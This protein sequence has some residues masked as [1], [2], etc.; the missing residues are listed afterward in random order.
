MMRSETAH[1]ERVWMAFPPERSS[2]GHPEEE[3]HEAR[4]AWAAIIR[5]VCDGLQV[6]SPYPHNRSWA[7]ISADSIWLLI[8]SRSSTK[9]SPA[10]N[11]GSGAGDTA[12][13][14]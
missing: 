4:T 12:I 1:Q 11:D 8:R 3:T 6:P 14:A 5:A 13:D 9:P 2:V 10:R 7:S